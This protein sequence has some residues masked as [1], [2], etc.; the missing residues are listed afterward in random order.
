MRPLARR[1]ALFVFLSVA[2]LLLTWWLLERSQTG[3][4]ESNPLARWCLAELGWGGL[5]LFKGA[6]VLLVTVLALVVAVWRR[7][8]A[9][10]LLTIG[11]SVVAAVVLYSCTLLALGHA[12]PL[13]GAGAETTDAGSPSAWAAEA[14]RNRDH[15]KLVTRLC[16][17]LVACRLTLEEAIDVLG[18]SAKA[19]TPGWIGRL[20]I[21]FES[22]SPRKCL[23]SFLLMHVTTYCEREC[24]S[25]RPEVVRRLSAA[26]RSG[27]GDL[28]MHVVEFLHGESDALEGDG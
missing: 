7:R 20:Q 13:G 10:R 5:T 21:T 16:A 2:D 24:P 1:I 14:R 27:Y 3:A 9:Q 19:G 17:D 12:A 6:T 25:Q 8:A 22:E 26:F 4:Y 23:A 28:P 11:C 18:A 15:V